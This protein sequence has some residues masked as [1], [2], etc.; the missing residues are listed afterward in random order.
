MRKNKT[1]LCSTAGY[2]QLKT[3]I[4]DAIDEWQTYY[5]C[6]PSYGLIVDPGTLQVCIGERHPDDLEWHSFDTLLSDGQASADAV[7][8]L[9]DRVCF[10]R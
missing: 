1:G 6:E 4:F 9:A 3:R 10:V 5:D 7:L 8:D 2:N